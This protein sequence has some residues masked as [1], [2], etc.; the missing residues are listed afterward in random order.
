MRNVTRFVALIALVLA[1]VRTSAWAVESPKT[2]DASKTASPSKAAD[3]N[4]PVP[5]YTVGSFKEPVALGGTIIVPIPDL[6]NWTDPAHPICKTIL[7]L[8]DQQL[9][10][11]YPRDCHTAGSLEF[12]LTRGDLKDAWGV[13]LGSPYGLRRPV[14]VA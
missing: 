1:F 7:Y 10:G 12:A 8:A 5:P 13:I 2:P 3:N 11:I 6:G 4:K 14:T 9:K